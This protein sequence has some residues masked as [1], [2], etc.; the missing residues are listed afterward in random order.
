MGHTVTTSLDASG[1]LT[2]TMDVPGKPVNTCTPQLLD[3]LANAVLE[4]E[5]T[6]PKAVI[7]TSAKPKSFNAGADLFEIRKMSREDVANYLAVGQSLFDRIAHLP[8]PT[9]AAINGD[10]LG[11]GFELALACRYRVAADDTSIS[12]GLPE[13]K[14]G[15]IPAWGGTNRLPRLIGLTR[16][17]PILLAGKTMPPR[18]AAKAGLIDETVRPEALL[19]AAKRLAITHPRRHRPAMLDRTIAHLPFARRK[20]L[21]TA[22]NKTIDTTH[23]HYPAP[24]RLID[25]LHTSFRDGMKAG[26]DAE[27]RAILEMSDGDTG[28]NLMR[29]FFL[30]QGA[31]KRAAE[32]VHAK[33]ADVKYAAVIGG[34]TMGAGITHALLRAGFFVRLVEVDAIAA[35]AALKRVK[36]L[37]DE[38]VAAGR[39]DKLAAKHT[40]NRLSPCTDWTGLELAD[41]VIEAVVETI[42]AKREVFAKLDRLCRPSAVL[43]SNT[44]SLSIAEM[45]ETT[46]HPERVVG[47]HFFNPVPKMP[48]VEVVRAPRSDDQSLATAVGL[49]ARIGKTPIVCTDSPGFVVNRILIPYLSEAMIMAAEGVPIPTIDEA[50]KRWGMPMGPFELLDEIGL[51]IGMHVLGT[52]HSSASDNVKVVTAMKLAMEKRWLGKKSGR[53][54]YIHGQKKTEDPVLNEPFAEAIAGNASPPAEP[55]DEAQ[56]LVAFEAIQW[57]LV[58]P[59]VN[60]MAQ[61]LDEDVVDSTD[62]IDLATVFGTGLAPFR[63]GLANFASNVGAEVVVHRLEELAREHGRRFEPAKLL[64]ELTQTHEKLAPHSV[65]HPESGSFAA[66]T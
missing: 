61:L 32:Q 45:A 47:M 2:V 3:D 29:L 59:M 44:S 39:L 38:D 36:G 20:V 11:G 16:A 22:R 34:G 30:R 42:D 12:I 10:C 46:L 17:L 33:P 56:K 13:T 54:F 55:L 50:M 23:G 4:I 19:A 25:V 1:V 63:G 18:K 65:L 64:R 26:L 5:K 57:R 31:K 9:V 7:F 51:D 28:R 27:R 62:T 41:F 21:D 48:L 14:L 6:Q 8:M 49:A 43:A 66:V 24:L 40:F 52:L 58:L 35:S 60:E 53:G 37:L 15:L